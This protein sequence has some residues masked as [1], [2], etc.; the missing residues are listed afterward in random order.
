[1]SPWACILPALLL[2]MGLETPGQVDLLSWRER[3]SPLQP[4]Q[5]AGGLAQ[6]RRWEL[7]GYTARPEQAVCK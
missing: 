1:M 7:A 5:V 3:V 2:C 6:S 4:F